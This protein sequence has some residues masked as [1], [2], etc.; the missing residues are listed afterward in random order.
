MLGIV[1]PC[2]TECLP[3]N[4]IEV[5]DELGIEHRRN[6]ESK[7]V[8]SGRVGIRC[9]WCGRGEYSLAVTPF[10]S[11]WRCGKHRLGD[12]L[13][14]ASGRSLH[15]VLRLLGNV[16]SERE[17]VEDKRGKLR[18][19]KGLAPMGKVH[20]RYLS[21]RGFDPDEIEDVWH[22]QGIGIAERLAFRLFIPV[23]NRTGKLVS[24]TTRSLNEDKYNRYVTASP[25]EEIENP[26]TLLYGE[27]LA[28]HGI[29][30]VEG[31][32]DAW[33]IGPGAVATLGVSWTEAQFACILRHPVRAVLYDSEPEAQRQAQRLCD[34]LSVHEGVT[35]RLELETAKDPGSADQA[36]I[37]EIRR[38]FL[39]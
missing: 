5:L 36:E 30:I 14:E 37:D 19:P 20:R 11:C 17:E 32:T 26:K 27:H 22:V 28:G 12:S 1:G 34:R 7:D 18:L 39:S 15:E 8:R 2:R 13:A 38:R 10:V 33:R 29:V 24:W 35:V 16:V 21:S 6:G 9:P 23:R 3:V 4:I 31:P 25:D